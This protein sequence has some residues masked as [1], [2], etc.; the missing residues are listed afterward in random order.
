MPSYSFL[1][2]THRI[3]GSGDKD[4]L[5]GLPTSLLPQ[6]GFEIIPSAD[7]KALVAYLLSLDRSHSLKEAPAVAA[8]APVGK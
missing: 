3:A 5:K 6:E 8:T 4:A 1:F 2:K 7:A